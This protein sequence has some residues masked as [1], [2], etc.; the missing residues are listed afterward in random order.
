MSTQLDHWTGAFGD[1]Y[2]ERNIIDPATRKD[3]FDAHIPADVSSVLEVGSNAGHNLRAIEM[4]R[5]EVW[6]VGT[7]PNAKARA[8]AED[9][10]VCVFPYDVYTFFSIAKF[11][12]VF[13]SGVLI[14]VPPDRLD[15]ALRNLYT[16][17]GKYLLAIEYRR[18]LLTPLDYRGHGD[19]LWAA[20]YGVQYQ[21]LFPD[22]DLVDQGELTEQDGFKDSWFWLLEKKYAPDWPEDGRK[23]PR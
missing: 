11:D 1:A 3:W 21:R 2:T 7:E 15:H 9:A 6:T 20:D 22:L 18:D 17:S 10:G 23:R 13:T 19:L 8:I 14:H 5:P 12:L 16:A 4:V